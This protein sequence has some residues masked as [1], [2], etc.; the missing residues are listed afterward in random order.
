[1]MNC[2]AQVLRKA[3]AS[4]SITRS[5]GGNEETT[6]APGVC[7]FDEPEIPWNRAKAIFSEDEDQE[8]ERKGAKR[9]CTSGGKGPSE[10]GGSNENSR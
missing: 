6:R 10:G 2:K 9:R 8:R 7:C 3:G 5:G 1:M 4:V